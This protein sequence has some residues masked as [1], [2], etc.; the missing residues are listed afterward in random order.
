MSWSESIRLNSQCCGISREG[1]EAKKYLNFYLLPIFSKFGNCLSFRKKKNLFPSNGSSNNEKLS[2]F[3]IWSC[4]T[5]VSLAACTDN[6]ISIWNI[7]FSLFVSHLDHFSSFLPVFYGRWANAR[8]FI[9]HKMDVTLNFLLLATLTLSLSK[10]FL[11][12]NLFYDKNDFSSGEFFSS[13]FFCNRPQL[14]R[15]IKFNQFE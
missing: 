14:P 13:L 10:T 12:F 7:L 6:R 9:C 8:D 4:Y 2:K 5:A 11:F 1:I 15:G 3:S